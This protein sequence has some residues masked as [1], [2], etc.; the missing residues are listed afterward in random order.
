MLP[1]VA[2]AMAGSAGNIYYGLGYPLVVAVVM[3]VVGG[4][5]LRDASPDFDINA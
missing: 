3:L 4:G 5:F 2:T 1:L